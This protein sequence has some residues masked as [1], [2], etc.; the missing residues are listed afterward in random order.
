[1]LRVQPHPVHQL[2]HAALALAVCGELSMNDERVRDDRSDRLAR[3]QRRVGI[4]EDHLH[5]AVKGLQGGALGR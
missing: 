1:M 3:V 2:L 5:V 4:L